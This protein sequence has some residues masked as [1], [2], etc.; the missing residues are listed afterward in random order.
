MHGST[1]D[2]LQV[3]PH[4]TCST[5]EPVREPAREKGELTRKLLDS[6]EASG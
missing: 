1:F 6:G 5:S 2:M 4:C 3:R